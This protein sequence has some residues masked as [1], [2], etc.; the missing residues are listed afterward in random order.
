M[1][2][3]FDGIKTTG[4]R[5]YDAQAISEIN[6]SLQYLSPRQRAYILG[7]IIEESG[8]NPLA[9]SDNDTYQGL[10][11]WGEDRYRIQSN[12]KRKELVR[13]LQEIRK[14][15]NNTTDNKSWTHGGE[16]SGYQSFRDAYNDFNDPNISFDDGYRAFSFGY[17]RPEG[18]EDSYNN[19]LKVAKQVYDRIIEAEHASESSPTMSY[20]ERKVTFNPPIHVEHPDVVRVVKPIPYSSQRKNTKQ[21]MQDIVDHHKFMESIKLQNN[22]KPQYQFPIKF[23]EGG[24]L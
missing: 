23:S 24:P 22:P 12:D 10:I 3:D 2:I 11:Q 21:V 16:G 19:R 13:Q 17:V 6:D 14:T 8:G 1:P 4:N 18:K 20:N 9:K 5:E 15:L 7:T